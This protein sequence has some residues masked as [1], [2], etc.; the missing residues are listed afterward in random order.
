MEEVW[1]DEG[2]AELSRPTLQGLQSSMG[3]RQVAESQL[4]RGL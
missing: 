1:S 2:G 3:Q 4:E